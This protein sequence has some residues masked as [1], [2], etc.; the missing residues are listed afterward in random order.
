MNPEIDPALI[1]RA[2]LWAVLKA[3]EPAV[4]TES[5]YGGK[6]PIVP[7]GE[8]PEL[9]QYGGPHIIYVHNHSPNDGARSYGGMTLVIADNNFRHMAKTLNIIKTTLD[10]SDETATDINN[11]SSSYT[12]SGGK[13]FLGVRF[14]WVRT[15]YTE[16][17]E[18]AETEGGRDSATIDLDYEFYTDYNVITKV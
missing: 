7:L 6:V 4:W 1:I 15:T 5:Q 2:Y 17:P 16:G 13:P 3:N 10:R 8:E 18:P 11:F 9:S 12:V 14:G